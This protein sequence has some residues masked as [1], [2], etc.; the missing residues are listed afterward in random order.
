MSHEDDIPVKTYEQT[1]KR[2]RD[3]VIAAAGIFALLVATPSFLTEPFELTA[4]VWVTL[5][6]G[7]IALILSLLMNALANHF[8]N[9]ALRDEPV[10]GKSL[11]YWLQNLSTVSLIV[12]G[13]SY[14]VFVGANLTDRLKPVLG[15]IDIQVS[16]SAVQPGGHLQFRVIGSKLPDDVEFR[17][18]AS[19]GKLLDE[20]EQTVEW[21]APDK[22][23]GRNKTVKVSVT[24]TTAYDAKTQSTNIIVKKPVQKTETDS[25]SG[26]PNS[27]ASLKILRKDISVENVCNSIASGLVPIG[28]GSTPGVVA[29]LTARYPTAKQS[30]DPV[31]AAAETAC[32]D[33][34]TW[35][36]SSDNFTEETIRLLF[37]KQEID[38]LIETANL[39]GWLQGRRSSDTCCDI[40]IIKIPGFNC[41]TATPPCKY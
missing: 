16:E 21:E 37:A 22:F 24:V 6:A 40:K 36:D 8:V 32:R 34:S 18:E 9:C 2:S 15:P 12:A 17:W 30:S 4:W 19:S 20:D 1:S 28:T 31:M 27:E 25:S 41:T 29:E 39:R 14:A 23:E 33:I 38:R 5:V 13:V 11:F 10:S 7:A 3:Y 26:G 35:I